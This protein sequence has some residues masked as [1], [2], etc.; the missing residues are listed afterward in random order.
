MVKMSDIFKRKD[1]SGEGKRP[2]SKEEPKPIPSIFK[3]PPEKEPAADTKI[4]PPKISCAKPAPIDLTNIMQKKAEIVPLPSVE[5]QEA[6]NEVYKKCIDALNRAIEQIKK[7][8]AISIDELLAALDLIRVHL[9]AEKDNLIELAYYNEGEDYLRNHLVNVLIFSLIIGERIGYSKDHFLQLGLTSLIYDLG[10][11]NFLDL[12][13]LPRKLNA[14]ELE[15]IHGHVNKSVEIL[16]SSGYN[17]K[18]D[19]IKK[20][21]L[22]H[23]ERIDGS[24][25]PSGLKGSEINEL[26]RIIGVVDTFEALTHKRAWRPRMLAFDAIKAMLDKKSLYDPKILKMLIDGVTI[27]PTGSLVLLNTEDVGKVVKLQLSAPL[28]PVVQ[29]LKDGQGNVC[30]ETKVIDLMKNPTLFIK[31]PLEKQDN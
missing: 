29:I 7:G 17:D 3:K 8:K 10:M 1:E 9:E 26:A 2:E 20:A 15:R 18:D 25:Y 21:I 4:E 24:G 14:E 13:Q 12:A 31:K 27:Y 22:E 19:Q 6:C 11:V 23:H 5:S 28:R 30:E 16:Q